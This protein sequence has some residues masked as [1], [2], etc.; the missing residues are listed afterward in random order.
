[1]SDSEATSASATTSSSS[2]NDGTQ[3]TTSA[4]QAEEYK[5]PSH[6]RPRKTY[7]QLELPTPDQVMFQDIMDN[8]FVKSA[9]SAAI[10]GVSG[11]AFGLFTAAMDNAGGVSRWNLLCSCCKIA[12][13]DEAVNMMMTDCLDR[14][15]RH[16]R[17]W[18]RQTNPH[19]WC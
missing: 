8:C 6:M 5:L 19:A 13:M 14:D 2:A 10:G 4:S 1:M 3:P 18:T 15:L 16:N 17:W 7:K 12:F 9:F 11:I